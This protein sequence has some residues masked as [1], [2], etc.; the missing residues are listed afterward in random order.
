MLRAQNKGQR[1]KLQR[2]SE[3]T[4]R[5]RLFKASWTKS[6]ILVFI[7]RV[8]RSYGR[9]PNASHYFATVKLASQNLWW[10]R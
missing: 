4:G 2:A 3:E 5:S 10:I 1:S 9:V 8:T 6:G 7:L